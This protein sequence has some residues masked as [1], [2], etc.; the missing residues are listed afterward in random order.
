MKTYKISFTTEITE[1]DI[2]GLKEDFEIEE[3]ETGISWNDWL[4]Q[5]FEESLYNNDY[6]FNFKIEKTKREV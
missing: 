1:S 4:R 3:S 5:Y 6:S 2:E